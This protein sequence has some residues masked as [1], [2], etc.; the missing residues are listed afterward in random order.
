MNE[1]D[2]VFLVEANL[3]PAMTSPT[4]KENAEE[5]HDEL[6]R[7]VVELVVAR[8]AAAVEGGGGQACGGLGVEVVGDE[9]KVRA[10]LTMA[11]LQR[12]W[13]RW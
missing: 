9:A 8:D 11:V 7:D 6:E 10:K 2:E 4:K 13:W 12:R 3:P 1:D 5:L